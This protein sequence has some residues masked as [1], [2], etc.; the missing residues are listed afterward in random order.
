MSA[1]C[2]GNGYRTVL[3]RDPDVNVVDV[4]VC[5]YVT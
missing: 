1:H 4:T 5:N 3:G 2:G